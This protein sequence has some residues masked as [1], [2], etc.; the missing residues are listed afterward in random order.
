MSALRI[1]SIALAALLSPAL[2]HAQ[3][4]TDPNQIVGTLRL[5]TTNPAILDVLADAPG[6]GQGLSHVEFGATGVGVTPSLVHSCTSFPSSSSRDAASYDLTVESSAAGIPYAV[7]MSP[8][9]DR[10]KEAYVIAGATSAPVEPDPAPDVVLDFEECLGMLDIRYVLDDGSPLPWDYGTITAGRE[11][12]PGSATFETQ[13]YARELRPGN[14]EYLAVHGGASFRVHIRAFVL[15]GSDPEVDRIGVPIDCDRDVSVD[16]D[17][18]VPITCVFPTGPGGCCG[19]P[20]GAIAGRIDVLGEDEHF[21][22]G[23]QQFDSTFVVAH[24][25]PHGNWRRNCL[26]FEPASG[27]FLLRNLLPSDSPGWA[28]RAGLSLGSFDRFESFLPPQLGIG[29]NP[30]VP[31]FSGVTTQLD[32]TFVIDPGSFIGDILLAGP[33]PGANGSLLQDL[34]RDVDGD[35]DGI[36]ASRELRLSRLTAH[37]VDAPAP[38]ATRTAAGGFAE[39]G[40]AGGMDDRGR[41]FLGSY[42]LRVGG[43]LQEPSIWRAPTFRVHLGDA[44]TTPPEAYHAQSFAVTDRRVP[45][46]QVDPGGIILID[47]RYCVSEVRLG[48]RSTT[49]LFHSPRLTGGGTLVGRDFERRT[50]DLELS[51]AASGT[52]IDAASASDRGLVVMTMPEGEWTVAPRVRSLSPR[53]AE[54]DTE[55]P[56]LSFHVGCRQVIKLVSQLVPQ[57]ETLPECTDQPSQPVSGSFRSQ[58]DVVRLQWW[59]NGGPPQDLCASCGVSPS[60]T[61]TAAWLPCENELTVEAED[62]DGHVA[63]V[64]GYLTFD[65]DP[66]VVAAESFTVW[67][68]NHG[69]WCFD[70]VA[71]ALQV[72]DACPGPTRI[73]LLSCESDQ[74]DDAEGDGDGHTAQDCVLAADGKGFCLRAERLGSCPDGRTYRIGVRATDACGNA[75]ESAVP[76]LVPHDWKPSMSRSLAKPDARTGPNGAPPLAFIADPSPDDD[77]RSPFT[78]P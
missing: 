44:T 20:L 67:P 24:D 52:P 25:G 33:R 46:T 7:S 26:R 50:V 60:F 54:S 12:S 1:R 58:V 2:A 63:S 13:A 19:D 70:D 73:E 45:D 18:M 21:V 75:T 6:L 5:R 11:T 29:A 55:L 78:C 53:G 28:V 43:L 64:T 8:W 38:G 48:Y 61:F 39:A 3:A 30:R 27:D 42:D 4:V 14:Q 15:L 77:L 37:G 51:N 69:Y 74:P 41:N 40:F 66:P 65:G 68:P 57:M 47:R 76:F 72:T 71:T 22:E 32:D 36:P 56:P 62:A 59:L 16:C 49:G 23:P 10:S 34:R 31:V 35:A 17:E 9:L